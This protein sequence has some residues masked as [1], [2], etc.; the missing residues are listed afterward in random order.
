MT[1]RWKLPSSWPCSSTC[2]PWGALPKPL[3]RRS[4]SLVVVFAVAAHVA[5]RNLD[6]AAA[7]D[8]AAVRC[9]GVA[10][11]VVAAMANTPLTV[12]RVAR[13]RTVVERL[14]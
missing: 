4:L 2:G 12:E 5:A 8:A 14:L 10:A 7:A 13:L 3:H 11:A 9:R 6:N 1:W